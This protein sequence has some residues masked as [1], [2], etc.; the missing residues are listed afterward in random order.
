M[1][2]PPSTHASVPLPIPRLPRTMMVNQGGVGQYGGPQPGSILH[3]EAGPCAPEAPSAHAA[4]PHST[5]PCHHQPPGP[6]WAAQ[7]LAMATV[8]EHEG[9]H[10]SSPHADTRALPIPTAGWR[11]GAQ[12]SLPPQPLAT[13]QEELSEAA[14]TVN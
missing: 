12:P 5:S 4:W 6:P 1:G 9:G 11:S 10:P 7:A 13:A 2:A 8:A 14:V 3:I